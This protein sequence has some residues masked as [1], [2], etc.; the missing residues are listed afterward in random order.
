MLLFEKTGG[1]SAF[2][3]TEIIFHIKPSFKVKV[4]K[5][6]GQ[7]ANMNQSS[8]SLL[9]NDSNV[10]HTLQ[11][12]WQPGYRMS[13]IKSVLLVWIQKFLFIEF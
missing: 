10:N 6:P 5:E 1:C 7:K 11:S 13:A 8:L 3:I 4:F 2:L 12:L 9:V